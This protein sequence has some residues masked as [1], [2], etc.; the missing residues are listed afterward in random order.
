MPTLDAFRRTIE[1]IQ[2]LRSVVRTMKALSAANLRQYERATA[3]LADYYA[4]V[5][6]GMQIVL[7]DYPP[8]ALQAAVTPGTALG[9]IVFGTDHGF[10]GQFNEQI[11]TFALAEFGRQWS[12]APPWR[13]IAVGERVVAWLEHPSV[14]VE[15]VFSLPGSVAGMAALVQECVIRIEEWRER[16]DLNRLILCYQTS[17]NG[18]G[19]SPR[20]MDLLPLDEAW[21]R[22]L[23]AR[24]WPSRCIPTYFMARDRLFA[25]L[26]RQY[27]ATALYRATALS[28]AAEN[29]S[30][31]AAMQHAEKNIDERLDELLHAYHRQ[32][33]MAI[34][35]ELLDIVAGVEALAGEH[36]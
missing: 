22:D 19:R 1:S 32:R 5:E 34:S 15:A 10:V 29:A 9:A 27:L 18:A 16:H 24:P 21:L 8:E 6:Q 26:V 17:G 23:A 31:L 3:A 4:T 33:Q 7:R 36:G 20:R 28:L 11:A 12:G 14:T 2:T 35:D 30:R 25:A 13:V